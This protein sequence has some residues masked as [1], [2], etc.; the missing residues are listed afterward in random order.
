M[1]KNVL[2]AALLLSSAV[3]LM[4]TP[5]AEILSAAMANSPQMRASEL[6][7]QNSQLTQQQYNLPDSVQV[8]VSTGTVSVLPADNARNPMNGR[9]T[10]S[11]DFSMAPSVEVVLPNDGQTT[12]TASTGLGFEYNGSGYYDFTPSI[13][14]K[15]TFDLTGWDSEAS[16]DL[17]SA[18]A[19]LQSEQVWQRTRL[20][21]ENQVLTSIK[22]I[23]QAEQALDQARYNLEVA[24]KELQDN[25]TLGLMS[26]GSVSYQQEVNSINLQKGNIDAMEKQI[27]TAQEQY[28]TLTDLDWDG[29]EELPTPDLTVN[30]L[31]T[32]NTAVILAQ[33]DVQIAEQALADKRHAVSPSGITLSGGVNGTINKNDN[34]AG[35]NVGLSYNA[36]NWSVGTTFSGSYDNSDFIPSLTFTGS[37]SNKTTKRSDELQIQILENEVISAQSDLTAARTSYVQAMQDLAN[38]VIS[39]N[40]TVQN[41]VAT[42]AYNTAALEHQKQLYEAGLCSADDVRQAEKTIEWASYDNMINTVDGLLLQNE[43]QQQN[44]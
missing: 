14:A 25:L 15:H 29:V 9:E 8:T 30:I 13:S 3:P 28:K 26:E 23:L 44:I 39:H 36:G 7:Y 19:S 1:K 20:S 4:A 33:I 32:G 10:V 40:Y 6:A 41:Q 42:D 2:L 37:W 11:P 16:A 43:I 35:G 17:S 12:I 21:F 31:P 18:R 38:R 22:A 24:E 34:S 5:Y 27:A